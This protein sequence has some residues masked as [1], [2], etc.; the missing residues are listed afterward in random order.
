MKKQPLTR[1]EVPK[2]I[3]LRKLIGRICL[4]ALWVGGGVFIAGIIHY[5]FSEV[6]GESEISKPS[7]FLN[8]I[9]GSL[10][11]TLSLMPIGYFLVIAVLKQRYRNLDVTTRCAI[12]LCGLCT[13]LIYGIL[14]GIAC[15][16]GV[17]SA[18][19]S[20]L[21]PGLLA[22]GNILI[23]GG[24]TV[25]LIFTS[26]CGRRKLTRVGRTLRI[27]ICM[28]I[29][30]SIPLAGLVLNMGHFYYY[31]LMQPFPW[32]KKS[33]LF[34]FFTPFETSMV[35]VISVFLALWT[36][37]MIFNLGAS[38]ITM[39]KG[40]WAY[41][42]MTMGLVTTLIVATVEFLSIFNVTEPLMFFEW[43]M[44]IGLTSLIF[45]IWKSWDS[46]KF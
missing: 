8:I 4:W 3:Q 30:S 26:I 27:I 29:V 40:A 38:H 37:P 28:V 15:A 41:L 1:F 45:W 5:W 23:P 20:P 34:S 33:D 46:F 2:Y 19:S 9:K 39:K 13:T 18:F 44:I 31:T 21:P 16:A 17:W 24:L 7:P 36:F 43:L 32:Q 11:C 6:G 35:F 12:S 22:W 10:G 25:T 42:L 14:T